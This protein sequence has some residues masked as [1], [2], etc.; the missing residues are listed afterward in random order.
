MH[1]DERK[2]PQPEFGF[3]KKA[4]VALGGIGSG[5]ASGFLYI[6]NAIRKNLGHA[7]MASAESNLDAA[8]TTLQGLKNESPLTAFTD[9]LPSMENAE[10]Q[11][12]HWN[13]MRRDLKTSSTVLGNSLFQAS[14]TPTGENALKGIATGEAIVRD[15]INF[16]TN[17]PAPR[18][19]AI[20][21]EFMERHAKQASEVHPTLLKNKETLIKETTSHI[22]LRNKLGMKG[23]HLTTGQKTTAGVAFAIVS[24][25]A[26]YGLYQC[27]RPSHE[28][29]SSQ[30]QR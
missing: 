10:G 24:S 3:L 19:P 18:S 30:P 15:N 12:A 25:V 27:L 13:G 16:F 23:V 28:Q 7:M 26:A 6:N 1:S 22:P 17:N 5:I 11:R 8:F 21:A 29:E 9:S 4:A 14:Q 2:T 20:E